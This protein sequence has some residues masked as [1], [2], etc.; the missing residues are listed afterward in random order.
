MNWSL[1]WVTAFCLFMSLCIGFSCSSADQTNA[2]QRFV[3]PEIK[4]ALDQLDHISK[5]YDKDESGYASAMGHL[6]THSAWFEHSDFLHAYASNYYNYFYRK[7]Q[8]QKILTFFDGFLENYEN[9]LTDNHLAKILSYKVSLHLQL[10]DNEVAEKWLQKAILLNKDPEF[11]ATLQY[12]MGSLLHNQGQYF[13]AIQSY[14]ACL[15]IIEKQKNGNLYSAV[16][17]DLSLAYS[18]LEQNDKALEFAMQA[19]QQAEILGNPKEIGIQYINTGGKYESLQE[20]SLA[21]QYYLKGLSFFLEDGNEYQVAR[22]SLNIG[23]IYMKLGKY[24]QADSL[25]AISSALS[26]SLELEYG[27]MLNNLNRGLNA[28]YMKAYDES[29]TY[30]YKALSRLRGK[31]HLAEKK[32]LF[33]NLYQL[34]EEIEKYDSAYYYLDKTIEIEKILFDVEKTSLTENMEAFY[35]NEKKEG[36]LQIKKKR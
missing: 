7:D 20:D 22:T 18:A 33:E 30:F 34:Y 14:L 29:K 8:R 1:S 5:L 27:L 11:K 23:N 28:L 4:A 2:S 36:Q 10:Y 24:K 26:E 9:H 6:Q 15:P 32:I 21:L 13:E 35:Q 17:S 12:Q 25:F 3:D 16:L 19:L 31:S